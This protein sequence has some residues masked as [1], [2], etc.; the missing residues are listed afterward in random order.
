MYNNHKHILFT[1]SILLT[2]YV[3]IRSHFTGMRQ[4]INEDTGK[5]QSQAIPYPKPLKPITYVTEGKNTTKI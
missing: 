3:Q 5:Q 2:T 4:S 1:S